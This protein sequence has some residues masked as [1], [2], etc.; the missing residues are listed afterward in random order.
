ME[1]I[2]EAAYSQEWLYK[3]GIYSNGCGFPLSAASIRSL[4][5][6]AGMD[7]SGFQC[8][9]SLRDLRHAKLLHAIYQADAVAAFVAS[10]ALG[11]G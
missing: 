4:G 9:G 8:R 3:T 10:R 11:V 1:A 5:L 2:S 7:C 6:S